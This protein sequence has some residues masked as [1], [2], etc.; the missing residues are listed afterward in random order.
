MRRGTPTPHHRPSPHP[1]SVITISLQVSTQL[2]SYQRQPGGGGGPFYST[3][4]YDCTYSRVRE[5]TAKN[6]RIS[7]R[8]R[9]HVVFEESH[10]MRV[11]IIY[12]GQQ[13][14]PPHLLVDPASF[15]CQC[16]KTTCR[17]SFF[18]LL[19]F[20]GL[21]QVY[22]TVVLVIMRREQ[23]VIKSPALIAMVR[24]HK[25]FSNSPRMV[26][27]TYHSTVIVTRRETCVISQITLGR[28]RLFLR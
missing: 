22:L 9:Q 21:Q 12:Y 8:K 3:Y 23:G 4:M 2:V 7:W 24:E 15:L 13:G 17:L 25:Y 5:C 18:H 28:L 20:C 19:I 11:I 16:M 14:S 1:E 26:Y 10:Q 6:N 27:S